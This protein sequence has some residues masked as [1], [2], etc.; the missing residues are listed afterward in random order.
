MLPWE[1]Y[2]RIINSAP[3]FSDSSAPDTISHR[4]GCLTAVRPTCGTHFSWTVDVVLVA[5]PPVT[6]TV[7]H[8]LQTGHALDYLWFLSPGF[9]TGKREAKQVG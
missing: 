1:P 7:D 8:A 3:H 9:H 4:H 5:V 2:I 6:E